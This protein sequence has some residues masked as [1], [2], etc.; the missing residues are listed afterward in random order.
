MT[1][2]SFT[3]AF[4]VLDPGGTLGFVSEPAAFS[5]VP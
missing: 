5:I 2:L 3:H 4:V 1:G